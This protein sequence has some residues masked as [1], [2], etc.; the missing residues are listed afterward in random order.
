MRPPIQEHSTKML[1]RHIKTK[2][3]ETFISANRNSQS[4]CSDVSVS[5]I[6][7]AMF[8]FVLSEFRNAIGVLFI[9]HLVILCQD[10]NDFC[11]SKY[12]FYIILLGTCRKPINNS[13]YNFLNS[14]PSQEKIFHLFS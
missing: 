10:F 11:P 1:Y 3:R 6:V 8:Y 2:K 4:K 7:N 12:N 14:I 5:Q 9:C 13:L